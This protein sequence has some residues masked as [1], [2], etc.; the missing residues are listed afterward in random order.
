MQRVMWIGRVDA[1]RT[2][3]GVRLRSMI[4]MATNISA[5]FL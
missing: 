3:A 4:L 1:R 5:V 2:S